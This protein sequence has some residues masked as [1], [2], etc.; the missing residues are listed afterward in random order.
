M[1]VF[2]NGRFLSQSLSG[3]QRYA[4]ELVKAI[5]KL[6]GTDGFPTTVRDARWTLLTPPN[7]TSKLDLQN[8]RVRQVGTRT[9]HLWDQTD[10]ARAARG[11]AL[12]SL[13]NAG[14]IIHRDHRVVIHDAQVFRHPEFFGRKYAFSHRLLG[15]VLAHRAKILTVSDFSRR[16]LADVLRLPAG[17]IAVCPNSAEHLSDIRPDDTVLERLGL[18]YSRYFLTVGSLTRNKNVGLAISAVQ[19]LGRTDYPLVVVGARNDRVF[20]QHDDSGTDRNII[21]AGRLPD[22]GLAALYRNARAFLFPSLYEGFGVPPLEA[23]LFGC[24]VIASNIPPVREACG[25]AAW[26]FDPTDPAELAALLTKRIDAG[27]LSD[28]ERQQQQMRLAHYSWRNSALALL[29]SFA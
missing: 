1:D 19:S 18:S 3:V 6:A 10:L 4:S 12:I 5:D 17:K 13:A 22:E 28:G 29:G 15:R 21:Y 27:P 14:P 25:D 24:P 23:M 9:G 8:I 2:I 7:A 16:E 11:G 20:G 26:F